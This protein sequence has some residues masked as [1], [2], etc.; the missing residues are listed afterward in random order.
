MPVTRCISPC[1]LAEQFTSIT[2]WVLT[3]LAPSR[4][5]LF[6]FAC[7]RHGSFLVT[8]SLNYFKPPSGTLLPVTKVGTPFG[9]FR[10]ISKQWQL[11]NM[12]GFYILALTT[13]CCLL[14]LLIIT[15]SF[16]A[17]LH[18]PF[19][20][21]F[22]WILKITYKGGWKYVPVYSVG[23]T[24]DRWNGHTYSD[25]HVGILVYFHTNMFV[26]LRVVRRDD[27]LAIRIHDKLTVRYVLH[28]VST[29]YTPIVNFV[30]LTVHLCTSV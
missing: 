8:D 19:S 11:E 17:W 9:V 21:I 25:R 27:S 16:S 18:T 12:N 14:Q 22:T 10:C 24:A 15:H 29:N 30:F 7:V 28:Q 5:D 4:A 2:N 20:R 3:L 26:W 1:Y 23:C 13:E 6:E